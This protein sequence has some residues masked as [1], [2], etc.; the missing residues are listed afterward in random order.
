MFV[1]K[2]IQ[3]EAFK[4]IEIQKFVKKSVEFLKENFADWCEEKE[5]QEVEI[6]INEIIDFAK[7]YQITNQI[8]LQ[9]LMYL[10]ITYDFEIPL[11][12]HLHNH[13]L[14]L[15]ANE[16]FRVKNFYQSLDQ[17]DLPTKVKTKTEDTVFWE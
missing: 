14:P 11:V 16:K 3:I 5:D 13:L 1:I 8:L 4:Q 10:K 9:K 6:F 17:D 7:E 12:E 15:E 2:N